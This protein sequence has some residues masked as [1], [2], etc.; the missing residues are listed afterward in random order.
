MGVQKNKRLIAT[1]LALVMLGGGWM[2]AKS[3]A[4]QIAK[5]RI[6]GFLIRNNLV[7]DVRYQDLSAS[8][9]GSAALSGVKLMASS[10]APISIGS[11]EISDVDMKGDQLRG[12]RIAAEKAEIPMLALARQQRNPDKIVRETLGLGYTTVTGALRASLRYDEQKAIITFE[13]DG[14]VKDAGSW[15]ARFKVGGVDAGIMNALY[16]LSTN[17]SKMGGL[18]L[19][20]IMGQAGE[21]VTRLSLSEMEVGID[22]SGLFKRTNEITD[23]DMPAEGNDGV[24]LD[25]AELVRAG[26]A[27]SEAKSARAALA[28]WMSKGGTLRIAA[29]LN[30]PLPLF[31]GSILAPSFDSVPSFLAV[32]K[33][34]ITN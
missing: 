26:M 1:G 30:Q 34:R 33:S 19:L 31:R 28:T 7:A 3:Q 21:A 32:T 4:T 8:P 5:D 13:T 16:G 11:V 18:A 24:A 22:N 20:G 6:D 15:K 9:F 17:V 14:D 25:E 2:Y 12:I 10:G 29:N 23:R 27:P